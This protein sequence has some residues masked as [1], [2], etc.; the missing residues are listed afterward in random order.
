MAANNDK[1]WQVYVNNEPT[2]KYLVI[3]TSF[4]EAVDEAIKICPENSFV[5]GVAVAKQLEQSMT[6]M[7]Y[8]AIENATNYFK[9]INNNILHIIDILSCDKVELRQDI[10]QDE[11]VEKIKHIKETPLKVE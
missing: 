10:S 6:Q 5:S 3:A 8:D 11:L 7:F 4:N 1:F 9:R 2:H